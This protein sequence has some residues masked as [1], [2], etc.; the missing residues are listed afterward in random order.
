M[1]R[2]FIFDMDGVLANTEPFWEVAK[3]DIF[4]H[5]LE[6]EVISR[7][8]STVGID[9]QGM[10]DL[11]V[12]HGAMLDKEKFFQAFYAKAGWVYENAT[13]T[14]GLNELG[15]LLIKLGYSIGVV[16]ASPREWIGGVID[17]LS[18]KE[19]IEYIISLQDREDLPHKPAPD[20]YQE[21]MRQMDSVPEATTILE[22][23]NAGIASA[24]SSGAFT[25][26]LTQNLVPGYE[27][28]GA[29]VYADSIEE[30]VK[31]VENRP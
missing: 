27:Q 15:E 4:S 14:P 13:L 10:Y 28:K 11:A 6:E 7:M 26:G 2:A 5:F 30:V 18:F 21:A 23:S 29:D 12:G 19:K 3:K 20:G 17:R 1:K 31:L 22:D 24:K 25:I 8:G 9:M 16:S